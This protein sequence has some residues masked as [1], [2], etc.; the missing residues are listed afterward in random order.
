MSFMNKIKDFFYDEE[1]IEEVVPKVKKET[2]KNVSKEPK[3]KINIYDIENEKNK[4]NKREKKSKEEVKEVNERDLFKAERTFNF[5]MDVDDDEDFEPVKR[6]QVREMK[7]VKTEVKTRRST[8]STSQNYRSHSSDYAYSS[9]RPY[10]SKKEEKKFKPTPVIS[11]IYGILDQNYKK[12]DIKDS[13][14][15]KELSFDKKE[16]DFDTIRR[17]AYKTLDDE[18]EKTINKKKDIFYN[19]EDNKSNEEEVEKK[20]LEEEY[21]EKPYKKDEDV[22]ITYND[23]DPTPENTE[24]PVEEELEVPK[25]TRSKRNTKVAEE[26]KKEEDSQDLFKIIDNMYKDP[27]D[28]EEEE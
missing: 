17:K 15:S 21:V 27:M 25:I 2:K 28:E 19:L 26:A 5:P 4:V 1:E 9:L 22:V 24:T 6:E 11:P 3:R 8:Q 16:V 13:N 14:K 12:E 20:A 7:P 23:E 18:L 10:Q